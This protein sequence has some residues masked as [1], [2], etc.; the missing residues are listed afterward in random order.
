VLPAAVPLAAIGLVVIGL[1][2]GFLAYDTVDEPTTNVEEPWTP[3]ARPVTG[4]VAAVPA[5][6]G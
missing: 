2:R 1:V 4:S 3:P 6:L 5:W